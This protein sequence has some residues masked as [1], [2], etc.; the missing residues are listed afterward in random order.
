MCVKEIRCEED[1]IQELKE[2]GN[3]EEDWIRISRK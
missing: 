2:A 1:C 3:G